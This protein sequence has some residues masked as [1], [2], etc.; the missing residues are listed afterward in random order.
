MDVMHVCDEINSFID[1]N[2]FFVFK[3]RQAKTEVYEHNGASI[4]KPL[5]STHTFSDC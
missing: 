4:N 1:I 3:V 5:I 2:I